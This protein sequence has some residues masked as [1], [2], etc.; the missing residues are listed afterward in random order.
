[1]LRKSYMSIFLLFFCHNGKVKVCWDPKILLP[2][3]RDLT[4][5][6]YFLTDFIPCYSD[7]A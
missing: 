6:F 5:S 7:R 1:M 2:W 3:Q 4:T